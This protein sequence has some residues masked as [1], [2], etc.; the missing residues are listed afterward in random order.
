MDYDYE[1]LLINAFEWAI[2]DADQTTKDLIHATGIS[3]EQLTA[4][5]YDKENFPQLHEW[6]DE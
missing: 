4:I 6:A 5:G 1:K 2:N 3:S